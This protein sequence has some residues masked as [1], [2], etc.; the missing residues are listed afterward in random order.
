M[1]YK[2]KLTILMVTLSI[3]LFGCYPEGPEY[4]EDLDVVLTKVNDG[5]DFA[6][7]GT[8]ALP[9][10]IVIIT[11]NLLDGDAPK[12]LPAAVATPI[13]AKMDEN[14]TQLGWQKVAISASPDVLLAPAAWETTTILY[15]YD[16]WGWWYGGYYPGWGG[17]YPG[18]VG[19]YSSGTLLMSIIDPDEL[20]GT[21]RPILQWTAAINGIL[22]G[23]YDIARVNKGVD[24]A[25]DQ[26]AYL[27]TN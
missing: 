19:S 23:N 6:G 5:Y 25:F 9:D 26:S 24:Q 8:Y 17:Y 12:F 18:Y 11:G 27:K 1:N 7:K 4:T 3:L 21:G 10:Q 16:Y 13:L 22:T 15:A 20:S 2:N 14:M